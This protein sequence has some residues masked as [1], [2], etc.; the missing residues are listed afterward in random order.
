[1]QR[2]FEPPE[3]AQPEPF[4]PSSRGKPVDRMGTEKCVR[5]VSF[6]LHN[7]V[8]RERNALG[9]SAA[10]RAADRPNAEVDGGAAGVRRGGR[11]S[12]WL[13]HARPSPR[14]ST[15]ASRVRSV[16]DRKGAGPYSTGWGQP[17]DDGTHLSRGGPPMEGTSGSADRNPL[18]GG[19]R[20][21]T[22][23]GE[24]RGDAG[25]AGRVRQ[26]VIHVMAW[27]RRS[28]AGGATISRHEVSEPIGLG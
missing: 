3:S 4:L 14:T 1:M 17:G 2:L 9:S 7:R 24:Q 19:L 5:D 12:S 26:E 16:Q 27:P 20:E 11:L 13:L 10:H 8:K 18:R 28:P 25:H 23:E 6:C 21:A 22:L 15:R